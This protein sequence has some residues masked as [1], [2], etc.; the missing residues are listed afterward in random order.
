MRGTG[1]QERFAVG[2][3]RITPAHAGNREPIDA[4]ENVEG[5]HPRAC[6][7]QTIYFA[8]FTT[9][10]GSPPRMRGTERDL[11]MFLVSVGITP[12]HAGN[13]NSVISAI[14]IVEDHPRACGEQTKKIP[15]FRTAEPHSM[16]FSFSLQ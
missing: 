8:K 12:A 5:D 13:S 10:L 9:T 3:N 16:P 2:V 4:I 14:V 7:E 11:L 6:G 15:Y 1:Q